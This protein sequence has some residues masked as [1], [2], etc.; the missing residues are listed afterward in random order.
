MFRFIIFPVLCIWLAVAQPSLAAAGMDEGVAAYNRGDFTT[1]L[2][3]LRPLANQGHADAQAYLGLMY[4]KGLG[5][6]QNDEAA[7]KWYT[8]A[9]EQANQFGSNVLNWTGCHP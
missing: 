7:V 5:I 4:D 3:E 1:A 8:R 2:R 9:A 6:P